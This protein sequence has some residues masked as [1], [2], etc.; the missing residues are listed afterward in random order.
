VCNSWIA[1]H[2]HLGKKSSAFLRLLHDNRPKKKKKQMDKK[3][4]SF[5]F[6]LFPVLC[7]KFP[8][9]II[10]ELTTSNKK[11]S[12][13]RV[14]QQ[15]ALFLYRFYRSTGYVTYTHQHHRTDFYVMMAAVLV[16]V[17]VFSSIHT[18]KLNSPPDM[19]AVKEENKN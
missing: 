9:Q 13:V 7:E 4:C 17:T 1:L 10:R 5:V 2:V 12:I 3:K 14:F 16:V 8:L 18:N 19:C 15:G 11:L 6:S